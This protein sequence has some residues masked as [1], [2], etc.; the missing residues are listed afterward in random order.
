MENARTDLHPNIWVL[1]CS[2]IVYYAIVVGSSDQFV[3][4]SYNNTTLIFV[5]AKNFY[6]GRR[7]LWFD[8]YQFCDLNTC[9]MGISTSSWGHMKDRQMLPFTTLLLMNF[10]PSLHLW[11]YLILMLRGTYTLGQSAALPL[12]LL[13]LALIELLP[14]R[15]S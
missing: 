15:V 7:E 11:I 2:D 5:H 14:T 9:I 6:L 12:D 1:Y 8:L 10:V 13:L 4:V 3:V